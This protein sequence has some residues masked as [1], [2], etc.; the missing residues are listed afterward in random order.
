[1]AVQGQGVGGGEIWEFE[2]SRWKLLYI[3]WI[4]NEALLH[5]TGSLIQY[6]VIDHKRKEY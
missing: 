2:V 4:N 6:P 5:I 1:M 3:E